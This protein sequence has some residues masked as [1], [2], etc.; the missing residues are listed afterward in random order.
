MSLS[1]V[2]SENAII[3]LLSMAVWNNLA[4]ISLY[5]QNICEYDVMICHLLL[6][7]LKENCPY[8]V[9]IPPHITNP[10][11]VDVT[12]FDFAK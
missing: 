3:D 6:S 8:Q 12:V 4:Q 5:F 2:S 11:F 7:V 10:Q 1:H 9:Q